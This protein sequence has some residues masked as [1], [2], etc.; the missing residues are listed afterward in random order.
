MARTHIADIP[1]PWFGLQLRTSGACLLSTSPRG[2]PAIGSPRLRVL[3]AALQPAGPP[4]KSKGR[5]RKG[6]ERGRRKAK[7]KTSHV[8]W[9]VQREAFSQE[10]F[11]EAEGLV[12]MASS[13]T[14]LKKTPLEAPK[15]PATRKPALSSGGGGERNT[16]RL[17]SKKPRSTMDGGSL[18]IPADAPKTLT[19][20]LERTFLAKRG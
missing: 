2:S 9:Q 13:S 20:A 18:I 16:K 4:C 11:A 15:P 6:R 7:K 1:P 19:E 8:A 17:G 10:S 12:Q 14:R 5:L 3:R